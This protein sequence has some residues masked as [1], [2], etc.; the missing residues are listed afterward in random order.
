MADDPRNF[1]PGTDQ[2]IWID[3]T[4]QGT[5]SGMTSEETLNATL[6]AVN[7][8]DSV[9][10]SEGLNFYNLY[11][12]IPDDIYND[13][14]V[15]QRAV[16]FGGAGWRIHG[17]ILHGGNLPAAFFEALREGGGESTLGV[18]FTFTWSNQEGPTDIDQNGK[19]DV[20]F[21]EIYINNGFN[22]QDAP[23]DVPNNGIADYETVVMHE[24]GHGLSQAHFGKKKV[25]KNGKIHFSPRA[26]MNAGYS[27]AQR[28]ITGTDNAGHCSIWEGW[29]YE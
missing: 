13:V 12:T 4:E 21:R 23:D 24:I 6:S 7:T 5:E 20:A 3:G 10:C 27:V 25:G 17:S 8:W 19:N 29:P 26:L 18:T 28:E 11:T 2:L 14:G 22:W 1:L 9:N 15:V 16:G